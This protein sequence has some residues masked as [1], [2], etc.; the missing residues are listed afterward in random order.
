MSF[1]TK[2]SRNLSSTFGSVSTSRH[3]IEAKIKRSTCCWRTSAPI[4][5]VPDDDEEDSGEYASAHYNGSRRYGRK[6]KDDDF[7]HSNNGRVRPF[8]KYLKKMTR[9]SAAQTSA[10]KCLENSSEIV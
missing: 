6:D 2:A 10:V 4:I 3:A 9:M 7:V 5:T 1:K 8:E